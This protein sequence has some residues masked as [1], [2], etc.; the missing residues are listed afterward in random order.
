MFTKTAYKMC[1]QDN[2]LSI[3]A[4]GQPDGNSPRAS[5]MWLSF[6]KIFSCVCIMYIMLCH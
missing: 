4:I 1:L 6:M 2:P 3:A 5:T